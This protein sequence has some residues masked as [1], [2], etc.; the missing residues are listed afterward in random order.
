[1][2]QNDAHVASDKLDD[3]DV[4]GSAAR[5]GDLL[6]RNTDQSSQVVGGLVLAQLLALLEAVDL[7]AVLESD[8]DSARGDPD[9]SDGC[10]RA[11]LGGT[12][13]RRLVPEDHLYVRMVGQLQLSTETTPVTCLV[14]GELG[15]M[16][17][18]DNGNDVANSHH[19]GQS[20]AALEVCMA[21]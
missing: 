10:K 11:D 2:C 3:L 6:V 8:N 7:D 18:S 5:E 19:L 9:S 1:M 12:S 21:C 4:A 17:S 16:T 20:D 13:L 15:S 14:A